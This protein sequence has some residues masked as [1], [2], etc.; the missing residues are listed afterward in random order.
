MLINYNASVARCQGVI[1]YPELTKFGRSVPRS[2]HCNLS[3]GISATGVI[4]A[5]A[6]AGETLSVRAM[7]YGSEVTPAR[8]QQIRGHWISIRGAQPP[9]AAVMGRHKRFV[10]GVI[11][12]RSNGFGELA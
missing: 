8:Q 9:G 7:T 1:C 5:H 11:G 10:R 2:V 12:G 3:P 4:A 6:L